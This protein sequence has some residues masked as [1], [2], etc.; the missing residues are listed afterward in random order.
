MPCHMCQKPFHFFFKTI[1]YVRAY[2]GCQMVCF[3]TKNSNLGI[4]LRALCIL[5]KWKY[6]IFMPF[7]IF[8]DH[9]VYFVFISYF[10]PVLV[11]WTNKNLATL[12]RTYIQLLEIKF[13]SSFSIK[14]SF[15]LK[16]LF[17]LRFCYLFHYH[18]MAGDSVT[19]LGKF[20]TIGRLFTLGSFG[21]N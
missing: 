17:P 4:F 12:V 9:L 18:N 3:Q 14:S 5:E 11:S 6:F 20:S 13:L 16:Y 8:Y 19:R 15:I 10:F 21:E 1:M 7:G 2:Q